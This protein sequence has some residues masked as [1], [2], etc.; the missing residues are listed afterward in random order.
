MTLWSY[1]DGLGRLA[2]GIDRKLN[3]RVSAPFP[4]PPQVTCSTPTHALKVE[5]RVRT[6]LGLPGKNGGPQHPWGG[7]LDRLDSR[8]VP[9]RLSRRD[10][11]L[12]RARAARSLGPHGG[13]ARSARDCPPRPH[14]ETAS[15]W[16]RSFRRA[17]SL[18]SPREGRPSARRAMP[19]SMLL[20]MTKS[21]GTIRPS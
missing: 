18:R 21:L 4:P 15:T 16:L 14:Q 12:R 8:L 3:P 10:D 6:P 7:R 20:A 1:V 19:R 13:V 11:G 5:T 17:A 9:G 2:T